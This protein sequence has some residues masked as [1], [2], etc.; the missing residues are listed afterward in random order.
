MASVLVAARAKMAA[1][2]ESL[3]PLDEPGIPYLEASRHVPLEER[4]LGDSPRDNTRKFQVR[5]LPRYQ[6]AEPNSIQ[7][8]GRAGIELVIQY[9]IPTRM[10]TGGFIRLHDLAG[11]DIAY[12]VSTMRAPLALDQFWNAGVV[13]VTPST[14]ARVEQRE[15]APLDVWLVYQ[16]FDILFERDAVVLTGFFDASF[17]DSAFFDTVPT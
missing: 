2:I 4:P 12:L 6:D 16:E 9:H 15:G 14:D 10:D 5:L 3:I 11:S 13:S 1:I 8:L 17:F 7:G